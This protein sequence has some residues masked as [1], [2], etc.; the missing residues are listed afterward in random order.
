[1]CLAAHCRPARS[2]WVTGRWI[3]LFH[4]SLTSN[5]FRR[6]KASSIHR[7]FTLFW[8]GVPKKMLKTESTLLDI[9]K[10]PIV[11]AEVLMYQIKSSGAEHLT[12]VQ[13]YSSVRWDSL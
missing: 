12:E 4:H 6:R 13:L 3:T 5:G 1:M 9:A 7:S 11:C 10:P 8:I 2:P